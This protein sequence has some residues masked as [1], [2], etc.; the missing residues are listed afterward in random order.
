MEFGFHLRKFNSC[1]RD[2]FS[3]TR[4]QSSCCLYCA[5]LE[6]L[7]LVRNPSIQIALCDSIHGCKGILG[8]IWI[9]R[10]FV[11]PFIQN[12]G[13]IF[14]CVSFAMIR[15]TIIRLTFPFQ[16]PGSSSFER[17]LRR[18]CELDSSFLVGEDL[19]SNMLQKY[20]NVELS[21][22]VVGFTVCAYCRIE[23]HLFQ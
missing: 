6:Y 14:I 23:Q 15:A 5:L 1:F 10:F 13:F 7:V 12:L 18:L 2:I 8:E 3:T 17:L 19:P 9:R 20:M 22:M 16:L 11:K 4:H 21:K